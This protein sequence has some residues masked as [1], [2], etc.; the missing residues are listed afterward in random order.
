MKYLLML[1]IL[2]SCGKNHEPAAQDLRDS[3]GDQIVNE[4]ETSDFEKNV[5]DITP[6]GEI[7]AELRFPQGMLQV[8]KN[9]IVFKNDPNLSLYTKILMVQNISSLKLDEFFSEQSA[10][11]LKDGKIQSALKEK[12]IPVTIVFKNFK[13]PKTITLI[14]KDKKIDLGT[15]ESTAAIT[16]EKEQLESILKGDSFLSLSRNTKKQFFA[17][18]QEADIKEKTYRVFMDNGSE[19]K[20]YYVA[21]GYSFHKFLEHFGIAKYKPIEEA[22]LLSLTHASNLPEWW[23][24]S[25]SSRD[26]IVINDSLRNLVDSYISSFKRE[27]YDVQRING[28]AKASY[29]LKKPAAA[30]ALIKIRSSQLNSQFE[31]T[32]TT[33]RITVGR[34]ADNGYTYDCT[35]KFLKEVN[36]TPAAVSEQEIRRTLDVRV[37]GQLLEVLPLDIGEDE[38]GTFWELAI[39]VSVQKL[40]L[41]LKN[42]PASEYF[43]TGLFYSKCD[44]RNQGRPIVQSLR[45]I[46]KQLSLNIEAFIENI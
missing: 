46:E 12:T 8:E 17:N 3:D 18:S 37:D 22:N 15:F 35:H 4:F 29:V 38:L 39:P 34:L 45:T 42:L 43:Q 25:L 33:E 41:S 11:Y 27:W 6:F 10:L 28:V 20:V 19:V 5:A 24:R 36:N 13:Q 1:L 30:K 7:E 2:A 26:K 23:V 44:G 9:N 16:L 32:S 14:T 31:E 40:E 21:K